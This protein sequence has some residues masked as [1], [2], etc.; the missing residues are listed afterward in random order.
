MGVE[1]CSLIK[2]K[3]TRSS[4]SIPTTVATNTYTPNYYPSNNSDIK[5]IDDD[6]KQKMKQHDDEIKL[7][8]D[9]GADTRKYR[10]LEHSV[11]NFGDAIGDYDV[12]KAYQ[13]EN[14]NTLR[15]WQ[16]EMRQ[17]RSKWEGIR[18]SNGKSLSISKSFAEDLNP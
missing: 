8:D 13:Y 12:K 7:I 3:D 5:Q 2:T 17:I 9:W 10:Q 18:L 16:S 1:T 11:T 6:L 14:I 4:P 15:Q